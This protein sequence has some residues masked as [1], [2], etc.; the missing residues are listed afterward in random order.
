M[1]I[2]FV[3][4]IDTYALTFL[5]THLLTYLLTYLLTWIKVTENCLVFYPVILLGDRSLSS[6]FS[7][8]AFGFCS[9]AHQELGSINKKLDMLS[10]FW[11]LRGGEI[12]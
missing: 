6:I 7:V 9:M 1:Y 8:V 4:K 2:S 12:K 11:L 10:G 5:L 3:R